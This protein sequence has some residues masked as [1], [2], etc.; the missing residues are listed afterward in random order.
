MAKRNLK[1]FKKSFNHII[2]NERDEGLAIRR[3]VSMSSKYFVS[4]SENVEEY[5]AGHFLM[6]KI[7][8]SV[9][10]KIILLIN[11]L[12]YLISST[13]PSK[14]MRSLLN[15][16]NYL[17]TNS[18]LFSTVIGFGS[19]VILFILIVIQY[20]EMN[21]SFSLYQFYFDICYG[22]VGFKLGNA[23]WHKFKLKAELFT[24]LI[25]KNVFW[26]LI[27]SNSA[28]LVTPTIIAYYDPEESFNLIMIIIWTPIT[29]I[30]LILLY[31]TSMVGFISWYLVALYLKS[32]F[33]EINNDI[34]LSLNQSNGRLLM[35]AMVEHNLVTKKLVELN[36]F[37]KYMVFIFYYGATP[38]LLLTVYIS[39]AKDT[40]FTMR[41]VSVLIVITI[42]GGVSLMNLISV[43]VRKSAH[44]SYPTLYKFLLRK[45]MTFRLR[46]KI[47]LF[48]E[49]LSSPEIAFYCLDL[50]P[51][52]SYEFYQFVCNTICFYI[53][54]LNNV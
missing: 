50:F 29:I 46:M 1:K 33:K 4:L 5:Y 31:S 32:K 19:F 28:I 52:N 24:K 8:L 51:M 18:Q 6:K 37:F 49:R 16:A 44:K 23:S 38:A 11:G 25:M 9:L 21:H 35:K 53:L 26:V 10:V 54:I 7:I 48:I 22:G 12:R 34:E 20:Q 17:L 3:I 36:E 45:R 39:H 47:E 27:I 13:F 2:E 43:F 14:R 42:F 40:I 15:D 41:V 30:Y